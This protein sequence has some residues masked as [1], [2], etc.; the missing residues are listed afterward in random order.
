MSGS[1][2]KILVID[3]DPDMHDVIEVMLAGKG[4][5]IHHC[6]TGN[7]GF[8]AMQ[9]SRPDLVLLDIMLADPN[10]G[11]QV[12][13]QMRQ[14]EHLKTIPII[15]MSAIG[16]SLGSEYGKEVCPVALAADMFLE[17]PLDAATVRE[18]VRWVLDQK[19][20]SA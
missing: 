14:N 15:F 8:D 13:C 16:E 20:P 6:R 4:Y 18:A 2:A 9:R 11:L 3:D 12:A 17:K 10:E 1:N 7:T 19:P 5:D